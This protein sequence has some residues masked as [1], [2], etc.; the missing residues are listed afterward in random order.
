MKN[1]HSYKQ[2]HISMFWNLGQCKQTEKSRSK[3]QPSKDV[4]SKI[5]GSKQEI[6]WRREMFKNLRVKKINVSG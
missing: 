5:T 3:K 6:K 1:L 2:V 4:D